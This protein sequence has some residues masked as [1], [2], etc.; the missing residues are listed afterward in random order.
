MLR[1]MMKIREY[2]QK[3]LNYHIQGRDKHNTFEFYKHDK[4]G[5]Y[6]R[7][8]MLKEYAY[9]NT[10]MLKRYIKEGKIIIDSNCQNVVIGHAQIKPKDTRIYKS[11]TEDYM[12]QVLKLTN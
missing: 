3:R 4:T 9:K 5:H 7:L 12:R 2:L 1:I 8:V 10:M 6:I 11:P